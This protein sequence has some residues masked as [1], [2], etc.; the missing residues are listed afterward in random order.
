MPARGFVN[1]LASRSNDDKERLM[2]PSQPQIGQYMAKERQEL[3]AR[4]R[5]AESASPSSKP[6]RV[7]SARRRWVD[8]TM[9]KAR[10]AGLRSRIGVSGIK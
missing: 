9:L 8:G 5:Q 6:K 3:A 4:I 2:F 7:R 1:T 10:L